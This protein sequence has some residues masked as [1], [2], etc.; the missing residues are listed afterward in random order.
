MKEYQKP[1][2]EII[3]FATEAIT[4]DI[5]DPEIGLGSGE[6]GWE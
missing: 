3:S 5:I 2:L 6:E 1:A 4:D